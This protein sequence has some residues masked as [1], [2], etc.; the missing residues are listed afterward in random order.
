MKVKNR[1]KILYLS[2]GTL[3]LLFILNSNFVNANYNFTLYQEIYREQHTIN[4]NDNKHF[5]KYHFYAT[6]NLQ[7]QDIYNYQNLSLGSYLNVECNNSHKINVMQKQIEFEFE[8]PVYYEIKNFKA[9][10]FKFYTLYDHAYL[11]FSWAPYQNPKHLEIKTL[12]ELNSSDNISI[13]NGYFTLFLQKINGTNLIINGNNIDTNETF[14]IITYTYDFNHNAVSYS[15]MEYTKKHYLYAHEYSKSKSSN[16]FYV[17]FYNGSKI[18]IYGVGIAG[19]DINLGYEDAYRCSAD[20]FYWLIDRDYALKLYRQ[21]KNLR[22]GS[23]DI[24]DFNPE[25]FEFE[26]DADGSGLSNGYLHNYKRAIV[27]D[28]VSSQYYFWDSWDLDYPKY[29]ADNDFVYVS[30]GPQDNSFHV[31]RYYHD[32]NEDI[33]QTLQYLVLQGYMK[34]KEIYWNLESAGQYLFCSFHKIISGSIKEYRFSIGIHYNQSLNKYYPVFAFMPGSNTQ[35]YTNYSLE[36]TTD[37][38]H[39][40]AIEIKNNITYAYVDKILFYTFDISA[41]MPIYNLSRYGVNYGGNTV[42]NF[43]MACLGLNYNNIT[44]NSELWV[45]FH[46]F[47][48]HNENVYAN[49]YPLLTYDMYN[50]RYMPNFNEI[51][52]LNDNYINY[53]GYFGK[54]YGV[55]ISPQ[56]NSENFD[57]TNL[58]F[59]YSDLTYNTNQVLDYKAYIIAADSNESIYNLTNIYD[60][61]YLN[62]I[63]EYEYNFT[64]FFTLNDSNFD[65]NLNISYY[66]CQTSDSSF[67][68]GNYGNYTFSID[69]REIQFDN[70]YVA[71]YTKQLADNLGYDYSVLNSTDLLLKIERNDSYYTIENVKIDAELEHRN[72]YDYNFINALNYIHNVSNFNYNGYALNEIKIEAMDTSSTAFTFNITIALNYHI[73]FLTESEYEDIYGGSRENTFTKSTFLLNIINFGSFLGIL[74]GIPIL[75]YTKFKIDGFIIGLLISSGLLLFLNLYGFVYGILIVLSSSFINIYYFIYKKRNGSD[76]LNA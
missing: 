57:I 33:N 9:N 10:N 15:I 37:V 61:N 38:W 28:V 13:Y 41:Y 68:S 3:F 53:S 47:D 52:H 74:L 60:L 22:Y 49:I 31:V 40:Y 4:L 54:K 65:F 58:L 73:C 35:F 42:K 55:S 7:Y 14:F 59:Q 12:I 69:F 51:Y 45:G 19:F 30:G 66:S 56:K 21:D 43:K 72:V 5:S 20:N 50:Y 67:T 34:L 48:N 46:D 27:N 16:I 18:N 64:F 11:K 8:N 6:F 36:L 1:V 26:N 75:F 2:L 70:Q 17:K 71:Y 29:M 76:I 39:N 24:S 32:L 63:S 44:D 62:N 23:S 25:L